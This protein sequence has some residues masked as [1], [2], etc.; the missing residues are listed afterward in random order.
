GSLWSTID[1][2]Q[3]GSSQRATSSARLP[4]AVTTADRWRFDRLSSS[5][6]RL[7]HALPRPA[8]ADPALVTRDADMAFNEDIIERATHNTHFR[9]VLS[10]G[11]HSQIV[12]MLIPAGGEIGEETHED[13]DQILVFTAGEG[14]AILD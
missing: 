13:V 6:R 3:S 5:G 8:G 9:E 11:P 2:G 10:T 4:T 14:E 7:R 1:R 12:V